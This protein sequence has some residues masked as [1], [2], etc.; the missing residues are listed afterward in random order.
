MSPV[1]YDEA[2][3][4][5]VTRYPSLL[6]EVMPRKRRRRL[7]ARMACVDADYLARRRRL[8]AA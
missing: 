6:P 1:L 8:S 3:R 5:L 4:R 7:R 2:T